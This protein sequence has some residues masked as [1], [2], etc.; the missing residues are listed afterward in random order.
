MANIQTVASASDVV[1]LGVDS[2]ALLSVGQIVV[3]TGTDYNKVNGHHQLTTVNTTTNKI[4]YDVHNL[5]DITEKVSGGVVSASISWCDT[6]DVEIWLGIDTATTNDAAFLDYCTNAGNSYAF[7]LRHEAGYKDSPLAAPS[8]DAKLGT[9]QLAAIYYRQRGS[10][11]SFQSFEQLGTGALPFG[12]M[13]TIRQ[14]L[15]V[16]KPQAR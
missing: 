5:A 8:P 7:R 3:V 12:S 13:A 16:N 1:T 10:V 15:G 6:D 2:A 9:I 14:L 11:D 4:T